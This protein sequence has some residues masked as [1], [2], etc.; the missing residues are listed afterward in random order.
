MNLEKEKVLEIAEA[1][2]LRGDIIETMYTIYPAETTVSTLRSMLR[3]KGIQSDANIKRALFYLEG[4]EY[5]KL[6]ENEN[7][8]D[9][10]IMLLPLGI[11]L[12]ESDFTDVGVIIDE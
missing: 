5:I 12:A 2:K 10:R 9:N 1:K 8:E 4:K 6:L 7:Y 11:N 3:Y